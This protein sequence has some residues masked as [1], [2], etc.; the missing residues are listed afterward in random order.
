[1]NP[2]F[3]E[4]LERL[5]LQVCEGRW[6]TQSDLTEIAN[7]IRRI[8]V[9]NPMDESKYPRAGVAQER[10]YPIAASET[11]GPS[12]Y[13]VSEAAGATS[14]PHEHQTWAIIVGIVGSET[15]TL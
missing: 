5:H 6:P 7:E 13:L 3:K 8:C 4:F 12:L 9:A 14:A 10:M 2:R 15:H 11:G 1:M